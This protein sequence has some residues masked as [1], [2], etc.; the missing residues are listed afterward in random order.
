MLFWGLTLCACV[1]IVLLSV[2][3][4]I[5]TC[6]IVVTVTNKSMSPT[7]A[8]GDRVVV[9]RKRWA[10][11]L[12]K[13]QIVVV[14][15][16]HAHS[17]SHTDLEA[18]FYIKRLVALGGETVEAASSGLSSEEILSD[19]RGKRWRVPPGS[20]F[21]LGD[22][23]RE[24]SIDSRTW[25]PLPEQSVQGIL[26]F[27]LARKSSTLPSVPT[28]V[29]LQSGQPAPAFTAQSLDGATHTLHE[30]IGQKLLLLFIAAT[31][32]CR[33]Q[34]PRCLTQLANALDAG[35]AV[36][37]VSVGDYDDPARIHAFVEEVHLTTP[38]L[39]APPEQNTLRKDYRVV[40]MPAYCLL[41]ERGKVLAAG[42]LGD[43]SWHKLVLA[44]TAYRVR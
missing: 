31:N 43:V 14:T 24:Q 17:E 42:F 8:S 25:G 37:C 35:I 44:G 1:S 41:D 28:L 3:V 33:Q 36:V 39:L 9:L 32:V 7:L 40:G 34:V 38:V 11:R 19:Q 20:L 23:E 10:P 16:P 27:K 4:V 6:L 2:L 15:L 18:L 30:Y 21:V 13:G 29:G 26:L 22:N 5:R 12:R